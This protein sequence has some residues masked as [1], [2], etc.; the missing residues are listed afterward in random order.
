M[1][2]E[3]L[4]D[5]IAKYICHQLHRVG[6]DLLEHSLLFITVG[7]FE[8]LLNEPRSVLITTEFDYMVVDVLISVST[9]CA[10]TVHGTFR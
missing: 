10:V 1:F 5:V 6:L 8:F 2:K 4:D 9:V 3:L 7:G